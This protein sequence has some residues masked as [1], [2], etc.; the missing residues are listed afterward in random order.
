MKD[1]KWDK[2]WY[3]FLNKLFV[4]DVYGFFRNKIK[5]FDDH[6]ET[7]FIKYGEK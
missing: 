2:T 1:N 5:T 4:T 7:L 3:K 6:W